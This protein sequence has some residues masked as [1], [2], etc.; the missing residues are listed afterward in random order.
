M[1]AVATFRTISRRK[2]ATAVGETTSDRTSA[3][4]LDQI[5]AFVQTGSGALS[6]VTALFGLGYMAHKVDAKLAEID[7]R[8]SAKMDG[9]K[10]TVT[11]EVDAKMAGVKDMAKVEALIVLK[12]YG[13]SV[14]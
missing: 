7:A 12:D 3:S 10:E 13:V 6:I 9:L 11:K 4:G 8:L 14:G 2:F 5:S 1:R